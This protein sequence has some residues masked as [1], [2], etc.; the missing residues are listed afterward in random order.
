[1]SRDAIARRS[2]FIFVGLCPARFNYRFLSGSD[3][4]IHYDE[5]RRSSIAVTHFV[6]TKMEMTLLGIDRSDL[7][8]NPSTK[9][10]TDTHIDI[11]CTSEMWSRSACAYGVFL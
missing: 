3:L 1:L 11:R 2:N 7:R 5:Y 4:F 6:A 10:E 9:R 8:K